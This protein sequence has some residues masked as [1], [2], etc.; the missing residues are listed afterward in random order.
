MG[1]DVKEQGIGHS[2]AKII[3]MGEHSVVYGKPAIALPLPSVTLTVT[4]E[5]TNKDGHQIKSRYFSGPLNKLPEKMSGIQRLVNSLIQRFNGEDD[6]WIMTIKS[7][8]PAERGM[9]SSAATAV[10]I[11]RAFFDLYEEKLERNLLLKLADIEEEVTHRSPSGLDAAT[12]S[13]TSP[14][15]FIKGQEGQ[16]IQMNLQATMIIA[17]TGVKGAT[18]DAI[19]AVKHE[20]ATNN[21][22][23]QGHIDH[24]GKL[25]NLTRHY[26][27]KN[28]VMSLGIALTSAQKELQALNVSNSQLDQLINV[29]NQNG[30]LGAKLTG[31]GRG[32]CMFA[33]TRTALGARK[34][35]GILKEQGA[36]QVWLQPLGDT[37]EIN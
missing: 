23:A 31:G 26:L 19:A 18:K 22:I 24:L 5:P 12:V 35:A 6:Q 1:F 33:I 10:A 16:P 27:R 34:L 11:V 2:H 8:L 25:V 17:D 14:L 9:G 4:M 28:D 30:A 37:E 29:A 36:R 32:G 21:D 3:L 13:S 15:Y 20:L 7:Q